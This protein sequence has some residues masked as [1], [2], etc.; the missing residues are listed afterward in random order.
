MTMEEKQESPK[1]K[2]KAPAKKKVATK[3][4]EKPA[5]LLRRNYS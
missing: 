1:P 2:A 5:E 4:V 3:T